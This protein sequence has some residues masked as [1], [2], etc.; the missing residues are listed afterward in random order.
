M[1]KKW[2]GD[3]MNLVSKSIDDF[4]TALREAEEQYH[5]ADADEQETNAKTQDILHSLELEKHTYNEYARLSQE[6]RIVRQK[7]RKAKETMAQCLP[8]LEWLD[9]NRTVV[10]GLEAL[11]GQ[12]RKAE[13][14]A[15][16]PKV[17]TPRVRKEEKNGT[18]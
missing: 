1:G 8:V 10:K 9:Q 4:L 13:R 11:L 6:L 14:I 5:L 2:E 12:V 17:Y 16:G 3:G 15:E 18:V 7:R